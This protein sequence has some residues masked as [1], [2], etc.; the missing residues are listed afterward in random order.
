MTKQKC[1]YIFAAINRQ[2]ARIRPFMVR[3]T[4]ENECTA[5]RQL[6]KDYVLLFAGRIPALG[7]RHV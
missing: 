1:T 2:Q 7:V 3:I 6:A 5:R 4:A